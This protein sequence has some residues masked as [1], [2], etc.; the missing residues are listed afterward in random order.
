MDQAESAATYYNQY[1]PYDTPSFPQPPVAPYTS[2]TPYFPLLTP[3][4]LAPNLPC[5]LPVPAPFLAP[6]VS[7]DQIHATLCKDGTERIYCQ[8]PLCRAGSKSRIIAQNCRFKFCAKC[9][10]ADFIAYQSSKQPHLEC[11][12]H[13]NKTKL[14]PSNPS[15]STSLSVCLPESA[16][17]SPPRSFQKGPHLYMT[18]I[19]PTWQ[20]ESARIQEKNQKDQESKQDRR[21]CKTAHG[22][23]ITLVIWHMVCGTVHDCLYKTNIISAKNGTHTHA[24]HCQGIPRLFTS[25]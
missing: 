3:N 23:Q 10:V 24:S 21:V 14:A 2:S 7:R 20:E 25:R 12:L 17:I 6:S 13:H 5:H 4:Q 18:S 16:T 22:H 8:G 15:P 1:A 9:C 11:G 19:G